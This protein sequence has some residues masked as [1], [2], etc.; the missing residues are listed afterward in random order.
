LGLIVANIGPSPANGGP[1]L[2]TL[3]APSS[4]GRVSIRSGAS[5]TAAEPKTSRTT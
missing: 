3:S 2:S 1:P 4:G 5:A